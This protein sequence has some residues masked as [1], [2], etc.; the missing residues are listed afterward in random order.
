MAPYE[1]WTEFG[2]HLKHPESLVNFVA[3]Y[4]KHPTILGATTLA[5]KRA[6]AR[7]IVD[8]QPGDVPPA[9]AADF[10]LGDGDWHLSHGETKTGIEDVDLW[11]G[12]LAEATSLNGGL[13]GSTFS[14]VFEKQLTD[15][16]DG[17]RFYYLNRTAGMNLLS[18]L[19][20]NS[21][22][23]M[24]QRN[25]DGT[26]ALKADAFSTVDCRFE[27]AHLEGTPDG[28][29]HDG[30]DVA[31][32][33][34]TECNEH[35]LLQRRPDGTIAYRATNSVDPSG[36][37]AQAVYDGTSGND[38]VSGGTDD[39]TFWGGAG[40]DTI[41]GNSGHDVALG[42]DGDDVVTDLDG[43]DTLKGGPGDDAIDGGPGLD[44]LVGGDGQDVINGGVGG[45]LIFGGP[46]TDFVIAGDGT[47][48]AQGD[49]GDDWVQG[50]KGADA[51][52]GD[53]DAPYFDDPG[54]V[55][56]GNDVLVGQAGNNKYDAEGGD[57]IMSSSGAVDAFG[58]FGGF[59]WATHQYDTVAA[60]DDL[61][62]NRTQ[63]K[64]PPSVVNRDSWQETEAVSG[65]SFD[66]VIRGDDTV[67][68][69]L[70][71]RG[72]TGCDVLDK[73]G[74]DRIH[75][76]AAL[77]PQD[78]TTPAGPVVAASQAGFCPVSGPVWGAGN[79][80][81]GGAGSDTLE[82]RGGDD[83][84]DGDRAL[85]VRISLRTDPSDPDTEIGSTDLMEHQFTGPFGDA[86]PG[87]TA[88]AG[89]LRR[90]GGS[91]GPGHRPADR[92]PDAGPRHGGHRGVL[93]PAR[94]LRLHRRRRRDLTVRP[95]LDRRH[96]PG[97]APR[98]QRRGRHRHPPQ[99]RAPAVRRRP[100]A[101]RAEDGD[102]GRRGRAGD[103]HL[104]RSGGRGDR[105]HGG[106]HQ[107][108]DGKRLLP[109]A[110]G[111]DRRQQPGGHRPQQ[112]HALQVPG[113]GDQHGR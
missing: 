18:Q 111:S 91:Q 21:F 4:G 30:A 2:Q 66:D 23:E 14:Y 107:H 63:A 70:G 59:D 11:V 24:I 77:L 84:I 82:G 94:Q 106:G 87:M 110:G 7:A 90:A 57:D 95:D 9:D 1:S 5:A 113:D 67:P 56:P 73:A 96:D 41:E 29:A 61:N 78:F 64:N 85:T 17:D 42:G 34:T 86:H 50:G 105:L 81:L 46:D 89:G 76:L 33:P 49:G 97:R 26:R 12:G 103:R 35:L 68:S 58:G 39:D 47:D 44:L 60:D 109:A 36:I 51:L 53:H 48:T 15:L 102:R 52:V 27:L 98:R 92:R 79:I 72:Y 10:M 40:N 93:R 69:T 108:E 37:N 13:L 74:V 32:D 3:A 45:N 31:D 83:I 100:T 6:A 99:H 88:P 55:T 65:S 54:Q 19:E 71:G 20:G 62:I 104:D 16:Q 8:P 25:T 112:R 43:A 38:R 75:G 28:F 80:L 22:A 101:A